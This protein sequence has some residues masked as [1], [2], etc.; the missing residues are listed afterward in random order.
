M[1]RTPAQS[2]D[3]SMTEKRPMDDI[4]DSSDFF[5][6][7]HTPLSRRRVA[8]IFARLGWSVGKGNW[9]DYEIRCRFAELVVEAESPI[10]MHGTVTEVETNAE[11]ILAPLR[12]AGIGYTAE[13]YSDGGDL[14]RE[15]RW[16]PD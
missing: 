15:F 7:L 12:E 14:L 11:H 10:L 3:G 16:G 13:C 2:K 6:S 5:A 8:R 4:T 9:T 1:R